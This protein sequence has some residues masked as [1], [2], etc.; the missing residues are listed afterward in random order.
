MDAYVPPTSSSQGLLERGNQLVLGKLQCGNVVY[1][2]GGTLVDMFGKAGKNAIPDSGRHQSDR[3]TVLPP[4]PA[5][6]ARLQPCRETRTAVE[7]LGHYYGQ[8]RRVPKA[9]VVTV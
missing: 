9:L 7:G 3:Q 6:L 5:G 2:N 8:V 4:S 1:D